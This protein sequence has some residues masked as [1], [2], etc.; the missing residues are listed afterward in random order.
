MVESVLFEVGFA[1]G[2]GGTTGMQGSERRICYK[3]DEELVGLLRKNRGGH[4]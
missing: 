3:K 4:I 1:V 2:P